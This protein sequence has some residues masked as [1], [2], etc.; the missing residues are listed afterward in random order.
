MRTFFEKF[1]VLKE[2][3]KPRHWD[4]KVP[5]EERQERL[6]ICNE[7]DAFN[8]KIGFCKECGCHIPSKTIFYFSECP[9]D[10]WPIHVK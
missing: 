1:N 7:C 3:L 2:K 10:K 9:R 6:R 8:E 5:D 4:I